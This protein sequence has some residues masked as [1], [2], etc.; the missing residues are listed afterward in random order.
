MC[1]SCSKAVI[2]LQEQFFHQARSCLCLENLQWRESVEP[3]F[4]FSEPT[5]RLFVI[6]K[7]LLGL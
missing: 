4:A 1:Y 3:R 6:A 2:K 5:R 7:D